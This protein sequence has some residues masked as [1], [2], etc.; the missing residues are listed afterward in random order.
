VDVKIAGQTSDQGESFADLY[1]I[2]I[3]G[4]LLVFMVMAAQFESFKDPFIIMFA[5]PVTFVGVVWAFKLT[6]LTLSIVTFVG[7]IML[8]GIVV[9]NGIVLVDY[10]N[11]LRKRGYSLYEA[12]QEAGRSRLRPVLMTTLTTILGMVPMAL[13]KGMGREAYSPLG[14]TMIGG[15]LIS[16]LITLFLV[17]AI[18]GIFH[19]SERKSNGVA[20]KIDYSR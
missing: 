19:N 13:S 4:I 8:V 5:I 2:L 16:T 14:V 15:L 7:M 6:G 3:L 11:L 9:K 18:Y 12:I 17:P 1:L 10:T 20:K